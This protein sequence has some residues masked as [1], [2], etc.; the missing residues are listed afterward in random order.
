MDLPRDVDDYIK[1]TIDHSLGIPISIDALQNK[2]SAAQESQRR[3]R[4]QYMSLVSRLK[5]KEQMIDSRDRKRA[6]TLRLLRNSSKRI[7]N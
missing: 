6:S 1:D 3:L 4:E 5:E 7:G 2:L